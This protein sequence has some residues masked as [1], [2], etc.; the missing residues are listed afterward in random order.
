MQPR[1]YTLS[2]ALKIKYYYA[3][4]FMFFF[5][6]FMTTI[7][8]SYWKITGE[9]RLTTTDSALTW[10]GSISA[11]FNALGRVIWGLCT[12]NF[13]AK[14]AHMG[15]CIIAMIGTYTLYYIT[16]TILYAVDICVIFFCIGGMNSIYPTGT[17]QYFG[18]GS[19][20]TIYGTIFMSNSIIINI[21]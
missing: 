19:F 1:G 15:M 12:D 4:W 14:Y 20:G 13:G 18:E 21:L 3:M 17:A 7:V 2:Q 6:G 10:V 16:S 5:N 8:S 11:G 9:E